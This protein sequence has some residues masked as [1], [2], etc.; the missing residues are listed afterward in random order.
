M[1]NYTSGF[2]YNLQLL[3]TYLTEDIFINF[4]AA[5]F[6]FNVLLMASVS[7]VCVNGLPANNFQE[8]FLWPIRTNSKACELLSVSHKF[9]I[10]SF[11]F[12]LF[13]FLDFSLVIQRN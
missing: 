13:Y 9:L 1:H 3:R 8:F 10:N 12:N 6:P 7:C 5:T 11:R 2:I 4:I